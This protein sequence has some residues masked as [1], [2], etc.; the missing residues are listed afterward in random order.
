M[1]QLIIDL[2]TDLPNP[3][4]PYKFVLD[5]A[6]GGGVEIIW[7][8]LFEEFEPTQVIKIK[9]TDTETMKDEKITNIKKLITEYARIEG[10]EKVGD[11]SE[12]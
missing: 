6:I 2:L 9:S 1:K 11:Q 4:S 5:Y 12:N 10:I 8:S 7:F 3:K